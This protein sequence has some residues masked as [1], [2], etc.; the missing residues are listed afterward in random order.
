MNS[1]I[2][3]MVGSFK[4]TTV[5]QKDADIGEY[6]GAWKMELNCHKFILKDMA[7]GVTKPSVVSREVETKPLGAKSKVSQRLQL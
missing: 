7:R 3:D 2:G 6:S 5:I 4:L 1:A